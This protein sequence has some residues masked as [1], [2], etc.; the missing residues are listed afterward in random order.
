[1]DDADSAQAI[2]NN[3]TGLKRRPLPV[4]P[5]CGLTLSPQASVCPWCGYFEVK[6]PK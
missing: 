1:M 4:C 2:I 3:R 5:H 6:A